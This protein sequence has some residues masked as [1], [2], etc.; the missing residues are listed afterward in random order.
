MKKIYLL[1][2]FLIYL[3]NGYSQRCISLGCAAANTSITTDGTL[4]DSLVS[5]GLGCYNGN[6]LKQVF[7]EYFFSV[8]GGD[9][10][11]TFTPTSG[12]D[13]SINYVIFDEGVTVPTTI[14][15]P[16]NTTGWSQI[17]CDITDHPN[18]P[19]GPGLFSVTATTTAGHY[20]AVAIIIWQGISTG[21]DAS[22]TF[23]TN[24]PQLGGVDLSSGNC[25]GILPVNLSSFNGDVTNCIVN[26]NWVAESQTSFKNYEVQYSMDGTNFKMISAIA[27]LIQGTNQKYSYQH[28]SP[29]AGN[30]YYRLKMKDTD[31][32]FQYSKVIT[33]KSDCNRNFL[34]IYPNPVKNVLHINIPDLQTNITI[35]HLYNSSGKMVYFG[36]MQNGIND[37]DMS[38]FA[39][40][41]YLLKLKNNSGIQNIK[42]IK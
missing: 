42:I 21:G 2:L 25:P 19:T 31:G 41:I 18:Q 38:K 12:T 34:F 22:Y 15:C 40:G 33:L 1:S 9:Y 5:S 29:A 39:Q 20:Y 37:I 26:L 23:D 11:Q 4:A 27:G 24:V 35:A 28:I 8:S 16:V 7:W 6:L 32:K 30:N 3:G 13:L 10:T 14:D 17:A 36:A